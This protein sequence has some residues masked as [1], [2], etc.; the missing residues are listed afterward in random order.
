MP[1]SVRAA[2]AWSVRPIRNTWPR[3]AA[4]SPERAQARLRRAALPADDFS[5]TTDF[6]AAGFLAARFWLT[7]ALALAAGLWPMPALRLGRLVK[8]A[9]CAAAKAALAQPPNS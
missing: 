9:R 2:I 3:P 8:A 4:R 1:P 5:F 6:R 7:V